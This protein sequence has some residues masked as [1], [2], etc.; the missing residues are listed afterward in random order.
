MGVLFKTA[1]YVFV[2]DQISKYLVVHMMNLASVGSIDVLPPFLNLRMA[3]NR[4]VN[5][6]LFSSDENVMRWVLI[7]VAL[8]ITAWVVVWMRREKAGRKALISAGFL[9][10][11]A[12]GNVVDRL[13]YGAVADFLNMSCCGIENPYAFNVADIAIFAGA[14]GL[15]LFT[16][17]SG[18]KKKGGA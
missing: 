9:V 15:V 11:G 8:V 5:F 12:L 6:G 14:L 7:A 16:G 18:K 13:I 17:T 2:I 4:G 1:A 3:W 10:G